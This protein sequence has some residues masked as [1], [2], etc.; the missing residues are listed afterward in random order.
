MNIEQEIMGQSRHQFIYGENGIER[1]QFLRNLVHRYPI[2]CNQDVPMAIYL[3]NFSLPQV[4]SIS[5][6]V[7]EINLTIIA[8]EY[9][10][11]SCFSNLMDA[12]L[13]QVPM[14][15]LD[16]KMNQFLMI[17]NRFFRNK[18]FEEIQSIEELDY[19]L[20]Q[21]QEMY[22]EAY[23]QLLTCGNFSICYEKMPISMLDLNMLMIYFKKMIHN[24]S[25]LAV[26]VD[27][28]EEIPILSMK[29]INGFITKRNQENISMKV[30][31]E[32]QSFKTY[33][34][35]DG[36]FAEYLHDYGIVELDSNVRGY[37]KQKKLGN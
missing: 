9:F 14:D 30:V 37:I 6:D 35:L 18:K 24:H 25:Y 26:V 32:F 7:D 15:Q 29:A 34:D 27:I 16:G 3:E 28:Q 5:H 36:V 20:K 23:I 1:E 13:K 11:F 10:N 33:E 21:V 4:E 31:S 12:F 2:T 8:R 17:V 19:I 22:R